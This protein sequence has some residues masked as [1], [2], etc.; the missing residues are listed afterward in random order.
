MMPKPVLFI[1]AVSREL[2]S[3]RDL[4]AK[5]LAFLGYDSDWQ[6]TFGTEQGD[7]KAML[8]RRIDAADGVVQLIGQCYGFE[9][10]QP[11]PDFGRVSFTQ[12]EALYARQ[13]G[14]KVWFILL[15]K[16]FPVDPHDSEPDEQRQLQCTYR[17]RIGSDTHL[18]HR[19][20]NLTE[21]E[22]RIHGLRDDLARL[23]RRFAQWAA[24]VLTL[25][26]LLVAGGVWLKHGQT[27]QGAAI[28]ELKTQNDKLLDAMREL[29]PTLTQAS[30]SGARE[31]EPTRLA[32]AYAVL[33]EKHKLPR[34][35]LAKELPQFAERLLQRSD[36]S[37]MDRA[38][39]LFAVKKFAEAETTA[40]EAKAKALAAAGQPVEDAIAAL[41]LAGSAADAQFHYARALEHCRAAAAL[42]SKQ[43]DPREWAR[44]QDVIA[45]VL[46]NQGDDV[47]AAGVLRPVIETCERVL[48]PE[49]P[50]TLRSLDHLALA[51]YYQGKYVEAEQEHRAVLAIRERVLGPEHPGTLDSRG[52]LA[53]AL[54]AQGKH[55]EA[56]AEYRS[57]LP[58]RERVQGPEHPDTLRI[59]SNLA[60]SLDAQG[61][62]AEAE[63][64]DRALIAIEERVLGRDH[65]DT[66]ATRN[67]LAVALDARGKVAEAEQEH[68]AVLAIKE[69]VL[70]PEHPDTLK[71]RNNLANALYEQG[72]RTEA[73][74]EFR[75]VLA[76]RER[77]LGPEHPDVFQSCHNLAL[78]LAAEGKQP[79]ALL[80][81]RRAL[82][83]CQKTLGDVHPDT[84]DAKELVERLEPPQ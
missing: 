21:L 38:S 17:Q 80:L 27:K 39:A 66:L 28:A 50:D 10:P 67:N 71:S 69:R 19:A 9:P 44:V 35:T 16:R 6:D 78:C 3:A 30:R 59:R 42:T 36:T 77:V 11:D 12:Y 20:S 52:N 76:I 54:D 81:A 7:L 62:S 61:K 15:G 4:V 64:E 45:F 63:T 40:L 51:M 65:P 2:H 60:N 84:K 8:R 25:L 58:I 26:L 82:A 34:G 68:R 53:L 33:E 43:R 22:N 48:G 1:S 31:D 32:R 75:A 70:G 73:E 23:R 74:A 29:A 56:E 24:L 5:T 72:K 47:Q 83:G 57:M 13:R 41:E 79:E 46:H 18:Y 37:V 49:H 55:A 14:R